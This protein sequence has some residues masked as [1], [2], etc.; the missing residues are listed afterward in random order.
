MKLL[1]NI[2]GGL[3]FSIPVVAIIGSV[4]ALVEYAARHINWPLVIVLSLSG[5]FLL[6]FLKK[7]K[8]D[9]TY[10]HNGKSI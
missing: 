9:K 8:K 6:T 2:F 10:R 5:L 4:G 3:V 1:V 7:P